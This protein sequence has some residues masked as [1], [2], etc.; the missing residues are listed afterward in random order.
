MD[1]FLKV[2]F[3]IDKDGSEKITMSELEQYVRENDLEETMVADWQ[4]LFDPNHTGGITLDSF[5]DTLGIAPASARIQRS[6]SLNKQQ[7]AAPGSENGITILLADAPDNLKD[8]ILKKMAE[9]L[10][11]VKS[12]EDVSNQ[13]KSYLD[14]KY[15]RSW[16]VLLT[17][18]SFW[19]QAAHMPHSS[20]YCRM[21]DICC[22]VWRTFEGA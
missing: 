20:C 5:C 17:D 22:L 10:G 15:G 2:F 9:L 6:E 13:M 7:K 3:A 8:D 4:R 18:D 16:V 21:N 19:L 1:P 12:K 11:S 14:E